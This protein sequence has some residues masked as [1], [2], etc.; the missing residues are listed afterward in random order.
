MDE[1]IYKLKGKEFR[2]SLD[3]FSKSTEP[4]D[5]VYTGTIKANLFKTDLQKISFITG[6][7][8]RFGESNENR[9]CIKLYNSL[10]K[11]ENCILILEQLK[12]ENIEKVIIDNIP[13]NQ[14]VYFNPSDE[15]KK[16]LDSYKFL[17]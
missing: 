12:C 3:E 6:V 14:L 11:Y 1:S 17:K 9:Y 16:Y 5:T 13:T 4:K 8:T 2:K 15:L 10:S 7:Y